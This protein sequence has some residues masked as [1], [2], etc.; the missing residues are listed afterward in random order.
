MQKV[1]VVR[2]TDL[3]MPSRLVHASDKNFKNHLSP[4]ARSRS[5]TR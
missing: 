5:H 3:S 1:K 2:G 4:R